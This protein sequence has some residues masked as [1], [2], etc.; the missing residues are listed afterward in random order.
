MKSSDSIVNTIVDADNTLAL[1][2]DLVGDLPRLTEHYRTPEEKLASMITFADGVREILTVH[3]ESW[4]AVL[5]PPGKPGHVELADDNE[6]FI[7]TE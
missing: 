2:T 7:W 3:I 5:N 4:R 6:S 1:I